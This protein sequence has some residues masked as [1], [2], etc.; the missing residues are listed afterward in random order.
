[1]P[2]RRLRP[3]RAAAASALRDPDGNGGALIDR[4]IGVLFAGF[5]A[6][7]AFAAVRAAWIQGV[8][9]SALSPD[10]ASQHSRTAVVPG[11]R[12][13]ILD[14]S[15]KNELAVSEDAVN[16]FATPYQVADPAKTAAKLAPL[17][18]L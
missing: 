7:L 9:G 12:G 1:M 11:L 10:P 4:R 18:H 2:P 3:L 14:R 15:G 6:L 17:L 5:V 8:Q 13:E 16:V